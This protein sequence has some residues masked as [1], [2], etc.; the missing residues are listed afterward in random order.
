MARRYKNKHNALSA[1][2]LQGFFIDGVIMKFFSTFI[3]AFCTA[4]AVSAQSPAP[5]P[6][7]PP[8]QEDVYRD[9]DFWLGD[10]EVTTPSGQV[11][12]TN[13]ITSQEYGCLIVEEWTNTGGVTGQSYN[14]YDPGTKQWRQVWVSGGATIDYAGGLNDQGEMVLEG[15]ISNRNGTTAPFRGTWTPN[16][17][18]SVR[19]YFQQYNAETEEWDDWFTGI[20]K[21]KTH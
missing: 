8:C 9:F 7:P 19:Q 5:T 13:K 10:W 11:A 17:D 18:G 21:K 12:G 16:E 1:A 6:P 4:S 3:F 20:Y 14:F 2:A 15:T